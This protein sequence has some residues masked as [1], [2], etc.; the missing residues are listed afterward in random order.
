[1][2]SMY[3]PGDDAR[4]RITD[5]TNPKELVK[6]MSTYMNEA[7]AGDYDLPTLTGSK[8]AQSNKKT[9]P[10]WSFQSRN[11]LGWYKANNNHYLSTQSPPPNLY[12]PQ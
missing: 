5:G 2:D 12:S 9:Q 3:G 4:R 11:K 10:N 1:M 7:G 8:I 6:A